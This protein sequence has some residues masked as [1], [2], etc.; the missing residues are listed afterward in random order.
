MDDFMDD[1]ELKALVKANYDK[2][3]NGVLPIELISLLKTVFLQRIDKWQNF[4]KWRN[5]IIE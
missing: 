2:N 3:N 1:L 5:D 4:L